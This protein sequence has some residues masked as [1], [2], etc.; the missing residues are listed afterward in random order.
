M[1]CTPTL[2]NPCQDPDWMI[3]FLEAG[4]WICLAAVLVLSGLNC[5]W[6]E[7]TEYARRR[8]QTDNPQQPLAP[9]SPQISPIDDS[10]E[11]RV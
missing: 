9:P 3:G 10:A 1:S 8:A 2:A 7:C 4:I 11:V 6:T 5:L